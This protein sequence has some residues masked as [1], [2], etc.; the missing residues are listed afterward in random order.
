MGII[1]ALLPLSVLLGACGVL[2]YLWAMRSGQYKDLD[3]P[4]FRALLQ[5]DP[6]ADS[7]LNKRASECSEHAGTVQAST[8]Q[9]S[10]VQVST[11]QVSTAPSSDPVDK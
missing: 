11:V 3:T 7:A 2:A 8:V 6:V 4:P 1:V 10:T 5:D 9:A